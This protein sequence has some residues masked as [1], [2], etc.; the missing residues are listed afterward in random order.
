MPNTLSTWLLAML[1]KHALARHGLLGLLLV[2]DQSFASLQAAR[3][4]RPARRCRL[5]P[6]F[7]MTEALASSPWSGMRVGR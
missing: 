3:D 6:L 4:L 7:W 5:P 2:L 1:H